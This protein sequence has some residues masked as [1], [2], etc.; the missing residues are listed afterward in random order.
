MQLFVDSQTWP[1]E[2]KQNFKEMEDDHFCKA[3][4]DQMMKNPEVSRK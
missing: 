2:L 4:H 3:A 1:E